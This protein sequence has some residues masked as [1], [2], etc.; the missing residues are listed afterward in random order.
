M[1]FST[2][3]DSATSGVDFSSY[4]AVRNFAPGQTE[5]VV[6]VDSRTDKIGEVTERFNVSISKV[7]NADAITTA[8]TF[9]QIF[10]VNPPSGTT[11]VT[12]IG[13]TPTGIDRYVSYQR[14]HGPGFIEDKETWLIFH[15]LDGESAHFLELGS[16]MEQ[17]DGI[18]GGGDYQVIAVDWS[19]AR[20]GGNLWAA[21]TWINTVAES[22]KNTLASWGISGSKVNL[23]GHSLGA[24]VA[25]ELS[26][27]LG[28]VNKLVAMN[29]ASTTL[30]GYDTLGVDFK[31]YSN[32]SWAFW[33]NHTTDYA[34]AS[35]TADESFIIKT[36]SYNLPNIGH[37]SAKPTWTNM[38]RNKNGSLSQWF[39]LDDIRPRSAPWSIDGGWEAEI[40]VNSDFM[41]T[42]RYWNA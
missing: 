37:G 15:G 18:R 23:V 14:I 19:A 25:F 11:Y 38:L 34:V 22:V 31:R 5:D 17:F 13:K 6:Y 20:T 40:E 12:N 16:A 21:A 7:N 35:L 41:P 30:G 29:P 24:Y 39:G 2:S 26:M 10:N 3:S 28:G 9:A 1:R 4:T 33:H 36:P 42:G 8:S 32:W 27:R